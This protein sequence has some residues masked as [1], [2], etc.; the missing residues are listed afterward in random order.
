MIPS[1]DLLRGQQNATG[2]AE[3]VIR[4]FPDRFR[5]RPGADWYLWRDTHWSIDRSGKVVEYISATVDLMV[6]AGDLLDPTPEPGQRKSPRDRWLSWCR[7]LGETRS[8]YAVE[9]RLQTWPG[10]CVSDGWDADPWAFNT[11]GGTIDLR[12]GQTRPHAPAD[13]ITVCSPSAE[14]DTG[15][16]FPG[17]GA[18]GSRWH[19]F[20]EQVL[21]ESETRAYL[22][23]AVGQSLIGRQR[24]HQ[25]FML[26]GSGGNGKGSFARGIAAALGAYFS[27]L[28]PS[29]FV[30]SQHPPHPTDLADLAGRRLVMSAEIP[31]SRKFDETRLKEITGGD[32]IKA[33][34]IAKDFFEF[35]P[36]H[37]VWITCNEKPRIVSN[38]NGVWRR[39][40]VI[41]FRVTITPEQMDRS[42]DETLETERNVILS[43]ALEGCRRYL[44]E[45]LGTCPEVEAETGD[46]RQSQDT[47]AQALAEVCDLGGA[48]YSE[49]AADLHAALVRWWQE[50]GLTFAPNRIVLGRELARRGFVATSNGTTRRWRGLRVREEWR[51]TDSGPR[52]PAKGGARNWHGD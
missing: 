23:K 32:K 41:P 11:S 45:G 6:A 29:F 37:T 25:V 43:W 12:T 30:E 26:T 52:W 33:R 16:C 49:P 2:V 22:Q 3:R 47:L 21:P 27:T 35:D 44:A 19:Q 9:K 1:A 4:A 17:D 15:F 42:L 51:H 28:P 13:L 10:V 39:M 20:L 31:A 46:Y 5:Y 14:Q 48:D 24:E 40:R 36:S 8:L 34:Y 50:M 38:D 7:D 18:H